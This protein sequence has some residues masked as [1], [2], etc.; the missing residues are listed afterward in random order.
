MDDFIILLGYC[1]GGRDT[2][3]RVFLEESGL[4]G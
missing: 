4:T 2:G 1:P 3:V